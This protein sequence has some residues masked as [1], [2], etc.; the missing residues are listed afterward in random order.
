[1]VLNDTF[2]L[3]NCLL[4]P[5]LFRIQENYCKLFLSNTLIVFGF[6]IS[7]LGV[8]TIVEVCKFS[9]NLA[10]A[11][12]YMRISPR[13]QYKRKLFLF[14]Q[15]RPRIIRFLFSEVYPA[16]WNEIFTYLIEF[17][18]YYL[19]LEERECH[20]YT[21]WGGKTNFHT[22]FYKLNTRPRSKFN[23]NYLFVFGCGYFASISKSIPLLLPIKMTSLWDFI[24]YP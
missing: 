15:S 18:I 5:R 7:F 9:F 23:F 8:H 2:F 14:S 17:K 1:M 13:S 21:V 20:I 3:L 11:L 12:P 10:S 4:S 24:R 22:F 6:I 16:I 19:L